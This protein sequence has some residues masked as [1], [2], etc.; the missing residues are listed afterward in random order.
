[1][2]IVVG[3]AREWNVTFNR[4]NRP[5][6]KQAASKVKAKTISRAKSGEE[7]LEK[8]FFPVS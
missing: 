2:G 1:M 5:K 3:T 4:R 8:F 6:R 7:I